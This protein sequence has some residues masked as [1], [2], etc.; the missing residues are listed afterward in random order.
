MG[1]YERAARSSLKDA[2]T[3]SNG[4]L[5]IIRHDLRKQE[6]RLEEELR[7][8]LDD[9]QDTL[10]EIA[11]IEDAIIAGSIEVSKELEKASKR[12]RKHPDGDSMRNII[13][14]TAKRLGELKKLHNDAITRVQRVLSRPPNAVE[15][16]ERLSRDLMKLSGSWESIARELDESMGGVVDQNP[17]L[18]LV[19]LQRELSNGGY[20][21]IL[22]GNDRDFESINQARSKISELSGEV[23]ESSE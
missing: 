1:R 17:P 16:I 13:I 2:T 19:E 3:L 20:D 21:T 18:E 6:I 11:S 15:S 5:D 7:S 23:F 4:V 22:A 8:R 12:H 10:V 9:V 14:D